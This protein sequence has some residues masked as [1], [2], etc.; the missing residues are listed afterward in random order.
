MVF[1]RVNNDYSLMQKV[2]SKFSWPMFLMG[3]GSQLQLFGSSLSFTELFIALM[4]PIVVFREI[5][6]MR[7]SGAMFLFLMAMFMVLGCVFSCCVNCSPAGAA[8]RG[9]AVS[10]LITFGIPVCH[11]FLRTNMNG[12]KW[13]VLG[14][15]ISGIL[16]IFV[17]K[18]SVEVSML[19]ASVEEIMHG[20]IFW[21]S[22]LGPVFLAPAKGWYLNCPIVYS[23]LAPLGLA[24]FAL[25]GSISGRSASLAALGSAVLVWMGRKKQF[26]MKRVGRHFVWLIVVAIFSI[27]I[28]KTVYIYTATNGLLGEEARLKY[29]AQ[30]RQGNSAMK[31]LLSGRM[32]SFC[33]LIYCAD[34]PFAGAGPWARDREGYIGEFLRKYAAPEDFDSY[35]IACEVAHHNG[36]YTEPLI[37]CH[38]MVTQCWLWF[39]L[40]GLLFSMAVLFVLV[41]FLK[42]DAWVVPQW[43]MWLVC[44]LPAFFWNF[45]F[46]PIGD[47]ASFSMFIVGCILARAVRKGVVRL[48][49]EMLFEIEK[50]ERQ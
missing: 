14:G 16:C 30:S 13:F 17:F 11:Y 42:Q 8:I 44:S 41:R 43:Y 22:R 28:F 12:F 5:P 15:A 2:V 18:K 33:G 46:S 10:L 32:E 1:T 40:P 35:K 34:H 29:E 39:G 9:L 38:S 50:S 21:I 7:R 19:G 20:P 37:P 48:P 6:F 24:F 4:F 36:Y 31:L 47:R 45:F 49:A 25:F 23:A 26:L 27:F 3:L